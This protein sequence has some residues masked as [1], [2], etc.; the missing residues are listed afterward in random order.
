[1]THTIEYFKTCIASSIQSSL[2]NF[3]NLAVQKKIS[4]S[5]LDKFFELVK[6]KPIKTRLVRLGG[7]NDGGYLLPDDFLGIEECFSPGVFNIASF[8]EEMICRGIKC[9]LCDNSVEVAPIQHKLLDFQKKHIGL[10][11]SDHFIRLSDWV[12]SKC[13]STGDLILQMDIEG[14]EYLAIL[15]TDIELLKRFRIIVIEF[16]GLNALF[17]P[18]GHDLIY[19]AFEKLLKEFTL[20]HAHP[21]NCGP[22]MGINGYKT[23]KIMEM[24]FLRNDRVQIDGALTFPHFLDRPNVPDYSDVVLPVNWYQ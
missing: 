16:H 21:N 11:N 7:Q 23:T 2:L 15:D 10:N 4:R 22:L 17:T 20:V 6:V 13:Q 14:A 24:T 1:M 18:M 12:L 5:S 19:G 8:E 9:Y 3:F